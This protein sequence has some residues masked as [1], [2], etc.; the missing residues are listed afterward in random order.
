MT[1]S[2]HSRRIRPVRHALLCALLLTGAVH[3]APAETWSAVYG[4][5]YGHQLRSAHALPDGTWIAAGTGYA[6]SASQLDLWVIRLDERGAILWQRWLGGARDEHGGE[7]LP[8]AD[9]G[10]LVV[11]TTES[12]GAGGRDGLVVRLDADG[13]VAWQRTVG[14]PGEDELGAVVALSGDRYLA[15]GE[16][17]SA[18]AGDRDA[19][20]VQLSSTGDVLWSRVYGGA[21]YDGARDLVPLGDGA[22]FVGSTW[23]SGTGRSDLWVATVA[24]DGDLLSSWTY[25]GTLEDTGTAITRLD[26]LTDGGLAVA[27]STRS[28]GVD[29]STD[30]WV[31]RLSLDGSVQWQRA[32]G[33]DGFDEALDLVPTPEGR[34]AVVGWT[35][36]FSATQGSDLWFL[37]LTLD[38]GVAES[39]RA[40]GGTSSDVGRVVGTLSDGGFWMAG[41]SAS[42]ADGGSKYWLL[43]TEG[44]GRTGTACPDP[45][46]TDAKNRSTSALRRKFPAAMAKL[47]ASAV[48]A[49]GVGVVQN[50]TAHLV[51]RDCP[52]SGGPYGIDVYG[53]EGHD[54]GLGVRTLPD[55][56][57]LTWG[58]SNS[59][60]AGHE[61]A[62][63]LATEET[64]EP[65]WSVLYGGKGD[66]RVVDLE[67][68]KAGGW[69][70]LV[71]SDASSI[72]EGSVREQI[73]LL[74]LDAFGQV[75][76]GRRYTGPV[77]DR[78]S[79]LVR[80]ADGG[81]L[82]VGRTD[83]FGSGASDGLVLRLDPDGE[84]VW[85]FA[86]GGRGLDFLSGG[87]ATPDGRFLLTGTTGSFGDGDLDGWLLVLDGDGRMLGSRTY[88]GSED[89]ILGAPAWG[90]DGELVMTGSTRSFGSGLRDLWVLAVEPDGSPLWSRAYGGSSEDFAEAP[91]VPN[92]GALV[93]AGS[94]VSKYGTLEPWLLGLGF[95]GRPAWQRTIPGD[96]TEE[97]T[98]V[99]PGASC[100]L[101]AT[102][103]KFPAVGPADS[104]ILRLTGDGK[105]PDCDRLKDSNLPHRAVAP[106]PAKP[107]VVRSP[108][109]LR[110]DGLDPRT[111]ELSPGWLGEC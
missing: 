105:I 38:A 65:A 63:I 15:A 110:P 49:A 16:S 48:P 102:G 72:L 77:S 1:R 99:A 45:R 91:A 104:W 10:F 51:C 92:A 27:G 42:Y 39:Q 22:A 109:G 53:A 13:S 4:G 61:D 37:D 94:T 103:G 93:V 62:W 59:N 31:Q 6:R 43:T 8:T 88:G 66:D 17:S 90:V 21:S 9:G 57:V 67:P 81:F 64:G 47:V 75:L 3:K 19:W 84:I 23:S 108:A 87:Q 46:S 7:V 76:W 89:D 111:T 74:R 71:S 18:G 95:E 44:D 2:P 28:F 86:Y 55:G 106:V 24:G 96:R 107:A 70:A 79:D 83:S 41:G 33:S 12:D 29:G 14:G 80:L 56:G 85:Q 11:G 97:V 35:S 98:A 54:V 26:P 30:L 68:S 5:T 100:D 58:W 36:I 32:L 60:G 82:V 34:L 40:Y 73:W 20:L 50:P 78:P 69:M 25:G 101:V 52:K